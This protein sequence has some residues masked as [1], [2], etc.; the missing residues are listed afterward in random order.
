[1]EHA[2]K[3]PRIKY[4]RV[5]V[6][7]LAGLITLFI[8]ILLLPR[9]SLAGVVITAWI[10]FTF[11][12]AGLWK[13]QFATGKNIQNEIAII[14]QVKEIQYTKKDEKTG[15]ELLRMDTYTRIVDFPIY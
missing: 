10:V 7:L 4:G 1:M 8:A 11:S 12:L 14:G 15:R 3:R 13:M 6:M 5:A 9:V 2:F